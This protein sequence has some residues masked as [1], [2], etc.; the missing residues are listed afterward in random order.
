MV[1]L[2]FI[3]R[4]VVKGVPTTLQENNFLGKGLWAKTMSQKSDTLGK[5]KINKKR[6]N[7]I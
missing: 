3:I 7:N 5:S 6:R 2:V 1:A 4:Y